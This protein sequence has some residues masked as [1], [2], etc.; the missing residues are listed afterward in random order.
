MENCFLKADLLYCFELF[1]NCSLGSLQEV[2]EV[3]I[4]KTPKSSICSMSAAHFRSSEEQVGVEVGCMVM[5]CALIGHLIS[6]FGRRRA[7][8]PCC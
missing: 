7:E 1:L 4:L 5:S 8:F 6:R 3:Y 2:S